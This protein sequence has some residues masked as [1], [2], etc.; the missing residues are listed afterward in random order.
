MFS[1]A[2]FTPLHWA[3]FRNRC[4]GCELY[5]LWIVNKYRLTLFFIF[6]RS[7]E[8]IGWVIRATYSDLLISLDFNWYWEA[9]RIA[10]AN[11]KTNRLKMK[12]YESCL[13]SGGSRIFQRRGRQPPRW[14]CQP[15]IWSKSSWKLHENEKI[16]TQSGGARPWRPPPLGSANVTDS[17]WWHYFLWKCLHGITPISCVNSFQFRINRK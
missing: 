1:P 2:A 8:F 15:I 9:A 3:M 5:L 10:I 4:G 14:E 16:W 12:Q 13:L 17:F 6:I 11:L 7:G